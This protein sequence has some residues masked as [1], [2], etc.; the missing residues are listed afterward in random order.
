MTCGPDGQPGPS[1]V[2]VK[3]RGRSYK[4]SNGLM[5]A[6]EQIYGG[7]ATTFCFTAEKIQ[8]MAETTK[9]VRY[10]S[11]HLSGGLGYLVN[12]T[13]VVVVEDEPFHNKHHYD[14]A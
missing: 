10:L 2:I 7:T 12:D 6:M 1:E 13:G 3:W 5:A 9:G 11:F 14:R 4:T 8:I